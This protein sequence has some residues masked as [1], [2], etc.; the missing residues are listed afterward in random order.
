MANQVITTSL[1]IQFTDPTAGASG[2]H[3]SAEI[4]SRPEGYNK[5]VTQFLMGD[6]P[7]FLVFKTPDVATEFSQ[8]AG[9]VSPFATAQIT[10]KDYISF[11]K[12]KEASLSKPP[13]GDVSFT[14]IGSGIGAALRVVGTRVIAGDVIT[15]VYK[16]EYTTTGYAYRLTGAGNIEMV[17]ILIEGTVSEGGLYS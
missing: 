13:N 10:M 17:L 1:V 5:G 12:S 11:A 9:N 2:A 15:A 8:T 4:D 3:L 14:Q 7:V 16:A 6:S